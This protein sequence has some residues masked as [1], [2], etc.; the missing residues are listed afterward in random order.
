MP[1]K[2][3]EHVVVCRDDDGNAPQKKG[4][5]SVDIHKIHRKVEF[6]DPQTAAKLWLSDSEEFWQAALSSYDDAIKMEYFFDECDLSKVAKTKKKKTHRLLQLDSWLRKDL[7][8]TVGP[9][10]A[11]A[12]L[13][14][15]DERAPFMSDEAMCAI[16]ACRPI[17]DDLGH[18][19]KLVERYG[20]NTTYH[21]LE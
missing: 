18:V 6:D 9:A 1:K 21:L 8:A 7:I 12:I 15:I 10:T 4:K 17:E 11:S 19:N 2:K 3:A 14:P 13:A 5:G 16:P 20:Q